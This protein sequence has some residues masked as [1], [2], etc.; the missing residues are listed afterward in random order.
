MNRLVLVNKSNRIDEEFLKDISLVEVLDVNNQTIL[1]EEE[2]Y[3]AYLNLKEY[4][5]HMNIIIS[6][7]SG[8]R[9]LEHQQRVYDN[10]VERYGVEYAKSVVAPVGCS[11]HH[12]GL[13][14]DID[15]CVDGKFLTSNIDLMQHEDIYLE[16]HKHL[17]KFGFI[18]RYMKG[19]EKITGY[20]YE[21][22]HLRYVGNLANDIYLSNLTLEEYLEK[23]F[24]NLKS[25]L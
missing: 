20:P 5:N 1:V 22:W 19:K 7:S 9:S 10:F 17:H 24:T 8:Y 11:E 15:I 2:T 12:T 25:M 16:I 18:L 3:E 21:P 6:I 23:N 4:L 14:I 13:A